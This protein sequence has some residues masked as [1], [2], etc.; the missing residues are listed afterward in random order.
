[1]SPQYDPSGERD[2]ADACEHDTEPTIIIDEAM[3]DGPVDDDGYR[4]TLDGKEMDDFL[5][6][7]ECAVETWRVERAFG[8]RSEGEHWLQMKSYNYTSGAKIYSVN[9]EGKLREAIKEACK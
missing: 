8:T 1:M 7:S 3:I 5:L 6:S 4:K 9:M 2:E